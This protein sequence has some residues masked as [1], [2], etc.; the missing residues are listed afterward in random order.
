LKWSVPATHRI[1]SSPAIGAD[2][3]IYFASFDGKIFAVGNL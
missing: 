2:G 1:Y 3:S